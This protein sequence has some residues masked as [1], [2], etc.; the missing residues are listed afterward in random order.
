MTRIDPKQLLSTLSVLLAPDGG[1]R[2]AEEVPRI[3]QLMQKFSKKLVSKCIYIHILRSSSMALLE[4]FLSKRGWD[5]LNNWFCD[6]LKNKNYYLCGELVKLFALCPMTAARL[7]EN[8]SSNQAPRLIKQ[9]SSD[10]RIEA[11][12]RNLSL[13]V[14]NQ[15][16]RV[17]RKDVSPPPSPASSA[18]K[19]Q[20]SG[21]RGQ[22]AALDVDDDDTS[23]DYI[24]PSRPSTTTYA[25]Q[26]VARLETPS[27]LSRKKKKKSSID[28]EESPPGDPNDSST[29]T[30]TTPPEK[31]FKLQN[32]I[33]IVAM[34]KS[35][36]LGIEGV[37]KK[38]PK[39]RLIIESSD[40]S[41]NDNDIRSDVTPTKSSQQHSTAATTATATSNMVNSVVV[42]DLEDAVMSSVNDGLST[43][44]LPKLSALTMFKRTED[45]E[46]DDLLGTDS[47]DERSKKSAEP[48]STD[49]PVKA[50]SSATKQKPDIVVLEPATNATAV[51]TKPVVEQSAPSKSLPPK[52]ATS[53]VKKA[54]PATDYLR[55]KEE[56][57]KRR[58]E[59]AKARER[60]EN[61]AKPYSRTELRAE[62]EASNSEKDRIKRIAAELKEQNKGRSKSLMAGLGR[63]PKLP[64][65]EPVEPPAT[66]KNGASFDD[67]LGAIDAKTK[68]VK[69]P[70]VKNKN[71]DL[72]ESLADAKKPMSRA[73]LL[74]ERK[75]LEEEREKIEQEEKRLDMEMEKERLKKE[76]RERQEKEEK[77]RIEKEEKERLEQ[78][79]KEQ[80]EKEEKER[81]E[82]EEEEEKQRLEKE[83]LEKAEKE[84]LDAEEKAKETARLA[85]EKEK[86]KEKEDQRRKEKEEEKKARD[87]R[88][89]E[90][91]E[92]RRQER[93]ERKKSEDDDSSNSNAEAAEADDKKK[94][95]AS[96]QRRDSNSSDSTKSSSDKTSVKSPK[97]AGLSGSD[98]SKSKVRD[99]Q[100]SSKT[101][102]KKPAEVKKPS[103]IKESN[104]FG[105]VLSSIMKDEKPKLKKR[106]LV[107]PKPDKDSKDSKES[108]DVSKAKR[109]RQQSGSEKAKEERSTGSTSRDNSLS[110]T[111]VPEQPEGKFDD[112]DE[113][114]KPLKG[115]LVYGR[116]ILY[117][118]KALR[119][120]PE[121]N[122]VQ[123][124]Y[125]EMDDEERT[126]VF[127]NKISFEQMRKNELEL[128]KRRG[129]NTDGPNGNMPEEDERPWTLV[130][131]DYVHPVVYGNDSK[132]KEVQ[133][134]RE[135][136]VLR[137]LFFDNKLPSDPSEPTLD[138]TNRPNP[139]AKPE[140]IPQ[141][142]TNTDNP[143]D[144]TTDFT[145]TGWPAISA[146][147]S[148]ISKTTPAS[149][150]P[151]ADSA[152]KISAT[153]T[154]PVVSSPNTNSAEPA[155]KK[156]A[157]AKV[158]D[159]L[160][161][162]N[163]ANIV[164]LVNNFGSNGGSASP[165][166]TTSSDDSKTPAPAIT[167]SVA[168]ET[169]SRLTAP[170][171]A[172]TTTSLITTNGTSPTL[173]TSTSLSSST[174]RTTPTPTTPSS[175]ISLKLPPPV[176]SV[177]PLPAAAAPIVDLSIPPPSLAAKTAVV[178]GNLAV[179]DKKSPKHEDRTSP[180]DSTAPKHHAQYNSH[181][182]PPHHHNH[183]HRN[184]NHRSYPPPHMG[185]DG[186]PPIHEDNG[187]YNNGGYDYEYDNGY[188]NKQHHRGRF[189]GRR[190][191]GRPHRGGGPPHHHNHHHPYHQGDYPPPHHGPRRGGAGHKS[192]RPCKFWMDTGNC[193]KG[194]RCDFS[195]PDAPPQHQP[196]H[197]Y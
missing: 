126:N 64:K 75:R 98:K 182:P 128:E 61:R 87:L 62:Q 112:R 148:S 58:R 165:I 140:A 13:Q 162:L 24:P 170:P 3:V 137:P 178:A 123:V 147:L 96:L 12:I 179:S 33:K 90:K 185:E 110:P 192:E 46:V 146:L 86:E 127:R 72:L 41:D 79:E 130:E 35:P 136:H 78:E 121:S 53:S 17:A 37:L 119:W 73:K 14:M 158:Q 44:T 104:I 145:L 47:D 100:R 169:N 108:K 191:N 180:N 193:R 171:S 11:E 22:F 93:A 172:S 9:L 84:R 101:T 97:S 1:I 139:D 107:E 157:A 152:G 31:K 49:P 16:K 166:T 67:V 135:M 63:I 54:A 120:Q 153:T 28:D 65:K 80:K 45:S 194:D 156:D 18:S 40:E 52:S 129:P 95:D 176:S 76:E 174:P 106:R 141:I 164:S 68:V 43:S 99:Q 85:K 109:E 118:K 133:Q 175:N 89:K 83:E 183:S 50:T 38:A 92:K 138:A 77:E 161:T 125:F 7:K 189:N 151:S 197:G 71:R 143:A 30:V 66:A 132:E 114:P 149:V 74:Q 167:N 131:L 32:D 116:S 144:T 4:E 25:R 91:E 42:V 113:D 88:R 111:H 34:K 155:V 177:K 168:G 117:K 190:N 57:E 10:M 81:K 15:W 103:V 59:V 6:G 196:Y 51:T 186:P 122:L 115:I 23:V 163:L 102:E 154:A 69:A 27:R 19:R 160:S 105:D 124:E 36:R 181:P 39:S 26:K 2:S 60:R 29:N 188:H 8:A 159:I 70:P 56:R 20:A 5:L 134:N 82:K 142:D 55:Q 21:G 94:K 173:S 187:G 150:K 48:V 195:H 184:N